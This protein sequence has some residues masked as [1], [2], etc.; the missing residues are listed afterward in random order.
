MKSQKYIFAVKA[1]ERKSNG[2]RFM[3]YYT[4]DQDG[5]A[6][7]VRFRAEVVQPPKED[8]TLIIERGEFN[9]KREFVATESGE[10]E[11]RTIWVSGKY[12]VQDFDA[13]LL[14]EF[15]DN[16]DECNFKTV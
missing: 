9:V 11:I 2:K 13:A 12:D 10:R 7:G 14:P 1:T 6:Y 4:Y 16:V 15:S 8:F 5:L 3:S